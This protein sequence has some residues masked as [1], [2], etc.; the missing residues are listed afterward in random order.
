MRGA[1]SK[2]QQDTELLGNAAM[3]RADHRIR[4]AINGVGGIDDL[5]DGGGELEH[6][7]DHVPVVLP[8]LHAA[9]I[10]LLPSLR[11]SQHP[12]AALLQK[13]PGRIS[14]TLD[15]ADQYRSNA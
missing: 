13:E 6:G 12:G 2:A 5:P 15:G 4:R 8:A 3:A 1:H 11:D 10:L 7:A 14:W 9:G